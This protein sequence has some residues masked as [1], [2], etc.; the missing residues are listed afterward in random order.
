MGL[1]FAAIAPHGSMA[2]AEACAPDQLTLAAATRA[3]MEELGRRF[4]AAR[5]AAAI[6]LTPH[7]VHVEGAMAVVVAGSVAGALSD[8]TQAGETARSVAL[9]SPTDRDLAAACLGALREAGVA[10]RGVSY[11]GND[12]GTAVMPMDWAVLVAL[13]FLGGRHDP[14]VPVVVIS[15]A[16]DLSSEHHVRA[17]AA[18]AAAAEASGRAVALVASCDHG[19][20]HQ[21]SGPYGFHPAAAEYDAE[22]VRL[23]REDDLGGLLRIDA[24]LISD[25]KCDSWWQLLMLHGAL[26]DGW[27]GELLSYE[28]PTYFGMLCAAY[29]PVR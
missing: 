20:A 29:A 5:P 8:T 17:G 28:A 19:H 15:P 14:P 21:A 18:L 3:A 4:E 7:N 27:R 12:A 25:A 1:V 22:V 24:R 9:R 16:R 2:I 6:V 23:V 26:G 11:G 13:W 10:V